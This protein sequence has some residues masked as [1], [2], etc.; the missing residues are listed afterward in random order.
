MLILV[1]LHYRA[2]A[3]LLLY[4]QAFGPADLGSGGNLEGELAATARNL[5]LHI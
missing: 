3:L 2:G 5:A 1:Q 4:S